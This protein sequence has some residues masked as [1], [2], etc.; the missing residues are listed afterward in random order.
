MSELQIGDRVQ[1]GMENWVQ[2]S[3]K[4]VS[5]S[6]MPIGDQVQT[7]GETITSSV[8]SLLKIVL[9]LCNWRIDISATNVAWRDFVLEYL[10]ILL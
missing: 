7:I 9:Q 2:T 1:T 10:I 5:V 4:L 6:E 8:L 3:M